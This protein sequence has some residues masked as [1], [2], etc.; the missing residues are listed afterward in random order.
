MGILD[1]FGVTQE[2]F[3]AVNA[4]G[5][6][7][8]EL[9]NSPGGLS[10]STY[11]ALGSAVG[12][13]GSALTKYSVS[14]LEKFDS[15]SAAGGVLASA[16]QGALTGAMIAPPYGA[17]AGAAIGLVS[18]LF[19]MDANKKAH[20]EAQ[21][22]T[23]EANRRGARNL[24]QS[25]SSA[26]KGFAKNLAGRK[27]Q[28]Y[29]TFK[30]GA[31]SS[32]SNELLKDAGARYAYVQ[33]QPGGASNE[34][35]QEAIVSNKVRAENMIEGALVANL[36]K[37][38]VLDQLED[39]SR[40]RSKHEGKVIGKGSDILGKKTLKGAQSYAEKQESYFNTIDDVLWDM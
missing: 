6:S 13:I 24:F 37:M 39:E 29:Q 5:L 12:Q 33:A 35:V 7:S 40:R 10:A 4:P 3:D 16:G 36:Q 23:R 20:A 15:N 32:K 1:E 18:G 26:H 31:Y 22:K 28:V 27:S 9:D 21:R 8:N 25:I 30:S 38:D 19:E 17:I 34:L 2:E 11:K 14:D